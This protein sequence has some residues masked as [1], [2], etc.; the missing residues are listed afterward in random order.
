M[1][2]FLVHHPPARVS[3]SFKTFVLVL[4]GLGLVPECA[5]SA[6]PGTF[7]RRI[8]VD[9]FGYMPDMV[10]VAVISDPQQGFNAAESYTPGLTLE[11]RTWTSNT[12]IFS[13]APVAW[14]NGLTHAQSGDRAWWFDFS[15]VTRW[16]DYYLYDPSNDTRSARFEIHHTVYEQVLKHATRVFYYQRRGIAKTQPYADARWTDTAS[17]LGPLQDTA[18][19]LVG[20]P[21]PATEKDLRGGWFDAGDYN[22]YVMFT[23]GTF[24]DLL[25]AYLQNPMI[26]PDD[27]NIPESGNGVPDLLDEVKWELDWLLRMQNPNGSVLS[28]MGVNA[29]QGASP[30]SA[31]TNQ[32]FYGAESTSASLSA[33]GAFAQAARAFQLTGMAAYATTL[34]NAAV[35]AYNWAVINPAV[36]FDNTGF[37]SANPEVDINNYA[38]ERDKLRTRA[39]IFLYDLTRQAAYRSYVE[40]NYLNIHAMSWWWWGP[41]EVSIQDALLYYRTLPGVTPAVAAEIRTRFQSSINGGDFLPQWTTGADAYRSYLSDASYHWGNNQVKSHNGLLF[42]HQVT[43]GLNP[44]Q[45]SAYQSAAAGYIHYLHGVNP[46]TMVYLSN[47]YDYGADYSANEMYH[48]WFGHGTIYDNAQSS[49]NGPA[50]GYVTGG[51][52]KNFQ[53]DPAYT[54][55]RLAPPMD[56]PVQKAYKDW[57][58][59]WPENSWEITEPAIYYQAGYVFLLSRFVRPL[60]YQDWAVGYGLSGSATNLLADPDADGVA[61]LAEYAFGLSPLAGD[62]DGLPQFRLQPHDVQGQTGSYLTVQFLRQLGATNLTYIVE[63]STNLLNWIPVCTAAGTNFPS[64]P[65]FISQSGTGYQ[66]QI[67]ARDLVP[68]ETATTPRFVRLTLVW[69]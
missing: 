6:P 34:S 5:T 13:G 33:A 63:G 20:N 61:N 12:L 18:C 4:I 17:F 11:L 19:R 46:L 10:K 58:T 40:S 47:M 52:N 7:A 35:A 15:P 41:Y 55:P 16:G 44:P 31:E 32:I 68:A 37:A 69:N 67:L 2:S 42:A 57:N 43:Y 30:P 49:P 65:G 1:Q 8:A 22:K 27:W 28:K 45:S 21:V 29:F 56:Q 3:L 48:S 60:T 39:A 53:P 50:C 24:S 51:A 36:I 54:G 62:R 23:D 14:S 26:W 59:S 9:Q 25:F 66:R 38:Y 64:G